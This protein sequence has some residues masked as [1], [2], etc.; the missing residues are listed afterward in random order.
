M[1]LASGVQAFTAVAQVIIAVFLVALTLR[2]NMLYA[3]H[4]KRLDALE[5]DDSTMSIRLTVNL[6][7]LEVLVD[8]KGEAMKQEEIFDPIKRQALV[9]YLRGE[10]MKLRAQIGVLDQ[11]R[12]EQEV[13]VDMTDT[14]L[15]ADRLEAKIAELESRY[16]T[17]N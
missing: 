14:Y 12:R 7:L 2:W 3:Q 8:F 6:V 13:N 5:R 16:T 17:V 10:L 4:T 15:I 9:T 1:N 11:L